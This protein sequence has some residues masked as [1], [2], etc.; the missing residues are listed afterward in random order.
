MV[1]TW[2]FLFIVLILLAFGGFV[3]F[4]VHSGFRKKSESE[5]GHLD[6]FRKEV[7][8][9]LAATAD[10]LR[11][12]LRHFQTQFVDQMTNHS[13][14]LN[15]TNVNLN[16]RLDRAAQVVGDVHREL[17]K[18]TNVARSIDDLQNILK[19]PKLRGGVGEL[20]LSEL[21]QQI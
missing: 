7:Q 8:S 21:L 6:N 15:K 9:N 13:Q 2:L 19:A 1:P 14:V 20:F 17:G 16:E 11:A 3:W 18:M 12:E 4:A 10:S 5:V